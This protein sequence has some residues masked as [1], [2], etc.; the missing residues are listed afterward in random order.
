MQFSIRTPW[1]TH[2]VPF[3]FST[4]PLLAPMAA[5]LAAV[6]AALK[7]GEIS[8]SFGEAIPVLALLAWT[9][10]PALLRSVLTLYLFS[11]GRERFVNSVTLVSLIAQGGIGWLLVSQWG[12]IGAAATVL[13]VETGGM[14]CLWLGSGVQSRSS[15]SLA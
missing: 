6:T 10:V 3:H 12:A 11:L 8:G 2:A 15:R 14:L 9:L 4:C 1:S 7:R 13:V 5:S